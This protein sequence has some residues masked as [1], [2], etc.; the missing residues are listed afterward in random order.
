MAMW[1][2]RAASGAFSEMGDTQQRHYHTLLE[3]L[4]V[5][6][7]RNGEAGLAAMEIYVRHMPRRA[8][9][10]APFMEFLLALINAGETGDLRKIA[11]A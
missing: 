7:G 11:G 6:V 5:W 9:E 3:E 10:Q 2:K 8:E 4:R 1:H